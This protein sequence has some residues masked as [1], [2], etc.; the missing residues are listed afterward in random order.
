VYYSL[1]ILLKRSPHFGRATLDLLLPSVSPNAEGWMKTF[2]VDVLTTSSGLGTY[3]NCLVVPGKDPS[4]IFGYFSFGAL[5]ECL[6]VRF[7]GGIIP[8]T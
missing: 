7:L 2:F 8:A 1:L 3:S 6:V 5:G 4:S